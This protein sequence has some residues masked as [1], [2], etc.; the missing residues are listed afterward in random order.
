M[1]GYFQQF[2]LHVST[3][4]FLFFSLSLR[5]LQTYSRQ[6]QHEMRYVTMKIHYVPGIYIQGSMSGIYI[7]AVDFFLPIMKEK[8]VIITYDVRC[9]KVI[10]FCHFNLYLF[11]IL[12]ELNEDN[13]T[14]FLQRF[15]HSPLIEWKLTLLRCFSFNS[16]KINKIMN[17]LLLY[18]LD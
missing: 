7:I 10:W 1:I 4:L 15:L 16:K 2:I 3:D 14:L 18:I 13:E 8:L 12:K 17:F 5:T 11:Q 9:C 6:Q